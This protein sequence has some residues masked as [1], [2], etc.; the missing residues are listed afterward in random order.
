M[1]N[2]FTASKNYPK[3]KNQPETKYQTEL[4]IFLHEL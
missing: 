3:D 2:I 1:I 4:Y